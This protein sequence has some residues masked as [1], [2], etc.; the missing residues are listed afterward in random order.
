MGKDAGDRHKPSPTGRTSRESLVNIL[1]KCAINLEKI[2]RRFREDSFL[3]KGILV[4][5]ACVIK[6]NEILMCKM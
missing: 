3:V 2:Q 6:I 5:K 4:A 1:R